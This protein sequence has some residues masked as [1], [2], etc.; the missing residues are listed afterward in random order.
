MSK[1]NDRGL[2]WWHV[3]LPGASDLHR[4]LIKASSDVASSDGRDSSRFR[5]SE[6]TARI[7]IVIFIKRLASRLIGTVGS[8]SNGRRKSI[9]VIVGRSRSDG[10][11]ALDLSLTLATHLDG[12]ILIARTTIVHQQAWS[13]M[14]RTTHLP[15]LHRT[16]DGGWTRTMIV[17]RSWLPLRRNQGH[18]HSSNCGH[19]FHYP[20]A[21]NGPQN[22]AGIPL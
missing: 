9:N 15:D 3:E 12:S 4:G 14:I 11:D 20:T 6:S 2:T 21:S 19:Q 8:S 16:A 10:H 13:A 7:A 1:W 18:D 5:Q 17:V 22:W